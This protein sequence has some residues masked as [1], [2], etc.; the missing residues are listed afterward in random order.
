[1]SL[2]RISAVV[3]APTLGL[4]LHR[5]RQGAPTAGELLRLTM[6]ENAGA[7]WVAKRADG[8]TLRLAGLGQV[9]KDL[10]PG[11]TVTLRVVTTS[12]SMELEVAGSGKPAPRADGPLEEAA[13]MRLDQ[14]ALRQIAW[15]TPDPALLALAWRQRVLGG[16]AALAGLPLGV[17]ASAVAAAAPYGARTPAETGTLPPHAE[18][19]L[20]P[21]FAWGGVPAML[22]VL[23]ADEDEADPA[24]TARRRGACALRLS[25]SLPGLGTVVVQVQR[26]GAGLV[27]QIGVAR[28]DAVVA[29]RER[30]PV[31]AAA[32]AG[33]RL[34]LLRVAV[35]Y[36]EPP[37]PVMAMGTFTPMAAALSPDLFRAAA[38]AAVVLLASPA[39]RGPSA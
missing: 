27:L 26:M 25:L 31:L 4:P 24:R 5:E 35:E 36:G 30:L 18:R 15:R 28:R 37:I 12:P 9:L 8:L 20:F 7:E 33:A 13:A 6:A 11:D 1:M 38:E 14:A 39:V 19:W 2:G 34:R 3:H 32:L 23:P 17:E 10:V 29:V 21:V 22:R 16:E